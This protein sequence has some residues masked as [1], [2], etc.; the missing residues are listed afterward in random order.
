MNLN[1]LNFQKVFLWTIGLFLLLGTQLSSAQCEE[2]RRIWFNSGDFVNGSGYPLGYINADTG[3]KT[4]LSHTNRS[5]GDIGFNIDGKLYGVT[6]DLDEPSELHE[7]NQLTGTAVAFA[8]SSA[9]NGLEGNSLSFLPD[10]SGLRGFGSNTFAAARE[11]MRFT[12]GAN[13]Q[14]YTQTVWKDFGTGANAFSSGKPGGDFVYLNG[15][16]Y[17]SWFAINNTFQLVEIEVDTD[18]NYVSHRVLGNLQSTSYGLA[19]LNGELYSIGYNSLYKLTI[20]TSPVNDIVKQLIHRDNN[21]YYYFGATTRQE[22][23][24]SDCFNSDLSIINAVNN[25]SP[26]VN[27]EITFTLTAENFGPD[28]A[29]N[30]LVSNQIP[31]GYEFVSA[32]PSV[33]TYDPT[34]GIWTIGPF[35]SG[36]TATLE[37]VLRVKETGNYTNTA[38]IFSNEADPNL[39]NNTSEVTPEVLSG[40]MANDDYYTVTTQQGVEGSP[41]GNV[42]LNDLFGEI[43]ATTDDV[44]IISNP[45]SPLYIDDLT[46]ELFLEEATPPGIYTINY[47]ICE[48]NENQSPCDPAVATVV[49]DGPILA[50]DKTSAPLG[51]VQEGDVIY[52]SIVVS[53][54][55][56]QTAN[57]IVVED[58]VPVGLTYVPNSAQIVDASNPVTTGSITKTFEY[59]SLNGG[60]NSTR[61][62]LFTESELPFGATLTSISYFVNGFSFSNT[63][64]FA[65]QQDLSLSVTSPLG[66]ISEIDRG[67]DGDNN[68]FGSNSTGAWNTNIGRQNVPAA[69]NPVGNFKFTFYDAVNTNVYPREHDDISGSLTIN[70]Q[71]AGES[72]H[73][74]ERMVKES[75]NV[76]IAPGQFFTLYFKGIVNDAAFDTLVNNATATASNVIGSVSDSAE[77]VVY[78]SS[79]VEGESYE[80]SYGPN[81]AS[82]V[83]F[84]TTQPG[85]N[86]GFV[87]DIYKLDN[88]FNMQ[89]NGVLLAE[90]NIEFEAGTATNINIEFADGDQYESATLQLY[91]MLGND[92]SPLIRV[93]ISPDGVVSMFGIKNSNDDLYPLRFKQDVNQ[94]NSFNTIPW[95]SNADNSVTIIQEVHGGLT[96]INGIA[97][98]F[99]TTACRCTQDPTTG[100]VESNTYVGISSLDRGED[101]SWVEDAQSGFIKLESKTLGFVPTRLTTAQRNQLNAEEGMMIWNLTNQC[102]EFYDGTNWVCGQNKCNL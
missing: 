12:I 97:Y 34:T 2:D 62:I 93:K 58:L 22:S 20:P 28:N 11:V 90:Q 77:N 35:A 56:N 27:D 5:F 66:V 75:D 47:E 54:F 87:F 72:T 59:V 15:K 83:T 21:V 73:D 91:N 92:E 40:P 3:V 68:E 45:T 14:G 18:Y 8:G 44:V 69:G 57:N 17:M 78:C 7:I 50:I 70:Y 16:I 51:N 86:A 64:A 32:N 41:V 80:W 85:T 65:N 71:Y 88:A 46:G 39:L 76:S 31:T 9:G 42:L 48:N 19:G 52:Y 82:P 49:V 37:V 43:E 94:V 1:L 29:T 38:S 96:D 6:Y 24:G 95:N 99:N 10:G 53:N 33:G 13:N 84:E 26:N 67:A 4:V 102:L 25:A 61:N 100:N 23:I 30:T 81:Q 60:Q 98:G 63:N 89:I 79:R 55:G 101:G 74:P 36:D